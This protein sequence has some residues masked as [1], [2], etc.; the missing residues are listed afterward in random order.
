MAV[1]LKPSQFLE[2][3]DGGT[4][5]GSLRSHLE[6]CGE[7]RETLETT[8]RLHRD[9][10]AL[11]DP[12][13]PEPDWDR[14]RSNVRDRLI[15]RNVQTPSLIQR[16]L[17]HFSR[18]AMA[19]GLTLALAVSLGTGFWAWNRTVPEGTGIGS[20]IVD[21]ELVWSGNGVFEELNDLSP[22]E[23]DRLRDLLA[24]EQRQ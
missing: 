19:W 20:E 17:A 22:A 24:S 16:M 10:A 4:L 15:A 18:P 8:T 1:H 21:D 12:N 11:D 7:C 23:A 6:S 14:F 2:I 9:V 5:R 13:I 3:I